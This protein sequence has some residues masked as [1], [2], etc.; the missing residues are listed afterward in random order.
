[1]YKYLIVTSPPKIL[2]IYQY[3]LINFM[4]E[5]VRTYIIGTN[6]GDT[7]VQLPVKFKM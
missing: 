7:V 2:S 5:I 3:S 4:Y 6:K 1:M